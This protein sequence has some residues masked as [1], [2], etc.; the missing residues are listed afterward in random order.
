MKGK[1]YKLCEYKKTQ[2]LYIGSTFRT[3]S[4]RLTEHKSD[5]KSGRRL[6]DISNNISIQIVLLEEID[7]NK[8]DL[9]Y[10]ERYWCE[11]LKPKYN[12]YCVIRRKNEYNN[13]YYLMN[14]KILLDKRKIKII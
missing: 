1:V 14:R 13:N 12:K 11:K 8:T 7:C 5:I 4:R 10:R 9:R 2:P 6:K 3:L